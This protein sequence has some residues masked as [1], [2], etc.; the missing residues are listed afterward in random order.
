MNPIVDLPEPLLL[1]LHALV[2]LARTPESVLSARSIADEMGASEGHLA[3]V[4][5][6]LARTGVLQPVHGPGGGYRMGKDPREI[7]MREMIEL[8]GGPFVLDGCGSAGCK[9]RHCL[10]GA[11]VDELTAAIRDYL[12]KRTLEDLLTH[13]EAKPEIT[14]GLS[15]A[16]SDSDTKAVS[17]ITKN[18]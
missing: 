6:K 2:A 4:L 7:N 1:G 14:I 11:L 13:F 12:D 17:D 9:G 16:G 8:L 3:K 10:I 5:Q 18:D 15:L